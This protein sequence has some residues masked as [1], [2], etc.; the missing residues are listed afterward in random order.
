IGSRKVRLVRKL[1]SSDNL[2]KSAWEPI[3]D[4]KDK[5]LTL[6]VRIYEKNIP[7]EI[8]N[9]TNEFW[10]EDQYDVVGAHRLAWKQ[11]G[12][13]LAQIPASWVSGGGRVQIGKKAIAKLEDWT[14]AQEL[15]TDTVY[16]IYHGRF[17][18]EILASE[19]QYRIGA[20]RVDVLPK[21]LRK[22]LF[23]S[24]FV[25]M[26]IFFA[27]MLLVGKPEAEVEEPYSLYARIQNVPIEK[28][29][30]AP[31]E[32]Q[33][34]GG[35]SGAQNAEASAPTQGSA[36]SAPSQ[37]AASLTGGLKSLMGGIISQSKVASNAVVSETGIGQA[38][39]VATA[40]AVQTG[41]L[42]A[43][44]NGAS[45]VAG[46]AK[47]G[48]LA[49]AGS[50]KGYGGGTGTG[51]GTG[52][53]SGVGSGVGN[54]IGGGGFRLI[55]EE[56]IVDGGLDKSVI[57][58]VIQNNLSQIKYCYERQ[59][60]ADP[61]LFG[62]VVVKWEITAKG[63]VEGALVKQTTLAS[64][65][66]ENCMLSKISGWKFPQPKNGSKVTVTYPFL[67]KSTR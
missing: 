31:S 17:I 44:G 14:S 39:A 9:S 64:A 8:K 51:L 43:V 63:L 18:V 26:V 1:I 25:T 59:L 42:A 34:A 5:T 20:G 65:P 27:W 32:Q 67:F 37:L 10:I 61:D 24:S 6:R 2:L 52:V 30:D 36:S 49:L 12:K 40:G 29:P 13:V 62:K 54:G 50:G 11:G 66:V 28:I 47:L 33:Q 53:G 56:S 35:G 45:N 58:A 60:V 16:R 22:P 3:T 55:E 4:S 48:A 46:A 19:G 41:K 57:A 23:V 38:T 15:E 7:L 21:D